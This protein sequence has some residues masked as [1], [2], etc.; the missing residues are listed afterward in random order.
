[1]K[2]INKHSLSLR[3]KIPN[4][5]NYQEEADFWD[6][7]DFA[8]YWDQFKD[9]D[10]VVNLNKPKTGSLILRIQKDL[11]KRIIKAAKQKGVTVSTLS[12]IWFTEKLQA[13]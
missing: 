4:F 3:D 9:I 13:A 12:R 8:D 5:K 10:L 11:K 1:M 7:H 2:K 6:T